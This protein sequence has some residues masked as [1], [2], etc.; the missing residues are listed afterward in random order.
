MAPNHARHGHRHGTGDAL[1]VSTNYHRE[2]P[3]WKLAVEMKPLLKTQ[4]INV[5][6][7]IPQDWRDYFDKQA[8]LLGIGR[9]AT[10]CMALKFGAPMLE[11]MLKAG[12]DSLERAVAVPMCL[13]EST[14]ILGVPTVAQI[15]VE[16]GNERTEERTTSDRDTINGS[17]YHRT[18]TK[19]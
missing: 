4:Y 12:K 1:I 16:T 11:A 18:R 7:S 17:T 9:N 15:A 2:F 8:H 10:L 13:S 5:S 14:K 3:P 19:C 6:L